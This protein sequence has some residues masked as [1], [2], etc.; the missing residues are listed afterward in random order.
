MAVRKTIRERILNLASTGKFN[1]SRAKMN[2]KGLSNEE[3]HNS[4]MATARGLVLEGKLKRVAPG[5]FVK[6]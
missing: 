6:K 3:L 1:R 2:F 4:I 5:T